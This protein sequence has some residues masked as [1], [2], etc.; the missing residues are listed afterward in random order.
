MTVESNKMKAVRKARRAPQWPVAMAEPLA[1]G[2]VP[3][4]PCAPQLCGFDEDEVS[5]FRARLADL[6]ARER[7]I[8]SA[9]AGGYS[10]ESISFWF[11]ISPKTVHVH[12]ANIYRKLGIKGT[13]NLVR[14]AI[15]A[16]VPPLKQNGGGRR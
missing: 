15:A 6:T 11:G 3:A 1:A 8:V 2:L 9:I 13:G 7:E 10:T 12:R 4:G 16:G 14:L 5:Q